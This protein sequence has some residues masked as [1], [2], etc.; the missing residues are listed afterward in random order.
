[1]SMPQDCPCMH[2]GTI[3]PYPLAFCHVCLGMTESEYTGVVQMGREIAEKGLQVPENPSDLELKI[4][5]GLRHQA[6]LWSQPGLSQQ[7]RGRKLLD[8]A[9]RT[10]GTVLRLIKGGRD[11]D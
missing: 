9:N 2:C 1:M 3:C 10:G 5:A 8:N 4:L 7:E 11:D 6:A